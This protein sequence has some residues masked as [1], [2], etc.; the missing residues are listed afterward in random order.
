MQQ[1]VGE[2]IRQLRRQRSL[3]QTE[4]GG[5]RFSKSYVS[6]VER[7]KIVPSSEALRF[8]AK[9]LDQPHDYFHLL[10]QEKA[11]EASPGETTNQV[12]VGLTHKEIASLMEALFYALE[13]TPF[14]LVAHPLRFSEEVVAVLPKQEQAR[15]ALLMGMNAQLQH[16]YGGALTAFEQALA[17]AGASDEL[18]LVILHEIAVTYYQT[19]A[20][21]IALTY[22]KRALKLLQEPTIADIEPTIRLKIHLQCAKTYQALKAYRQA[23][24]Q[25]EQAQRYL[26]PA[27][28]IE[29]AAQLYRGLAYCNYAYTYQNTIPGGSALSSLHPLGDEEMEKNFEHALSDMVK[30]RTLYHICGDTVSESATSLMQVMIVLDFC[31]R[32]QHLLKETQGGSRQRDYTALLA[33]AEEQCRKIITF[34]QEALATK[35]PPLQVVEELV[36]ITLAYLIR[37][38]VMSGTYARLNNHRDKA[39]QQMRWAM[40]L[41]QQV[42]ETINDRDTFQE[43]MRSGELLQENPAA[44]STFDLT[45]PLSIRLPQPDEQRI[46]SVG[47]QEMYFAAGELMEEAGAVATEGAIAYEYYEKADQFFRG[48]LS[49]ASAPTP[50]LATQPLQTLAVITDMSDM[51]RRY[52]RYIGILEERLRVTPSLGQQTIKL[53]LAVLKEG[54]SFT[55]TSTML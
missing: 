1:S 17:L 10:T 30:S 8:F 9:Q 51:T 2:I 49:M 45:G 43:R 6:A 11:H 44:L 52:Q 48:T 25:Y 16:E 55:Q 32:R 46:L 20:Y 18:Q 4:L 31:T 33:D 24:H 35:T 22:H 13:Q 40:V 54:L 12:E 3:T 5:D 38:F 37:I 36:D 50:V 42:L 26:S 34:Y 14:A 15:Y 47:K 21:E 27:S 28:A 53:L 7:E 29:I 39:E 19:Q 23:A 41:C